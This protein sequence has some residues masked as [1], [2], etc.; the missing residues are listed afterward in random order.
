MISKNIINKFKFVLLILSIQPV[1]AF[2]VNWLMLQGVESP[3]IDHQLFVF[4]QPSYT[5]D[6]GNEISV[7]PNSGKRTASTTIAPWFEDDSKFHIRRARAGIRGNFTGL[8][9]NDFS[10]KMNYF[11]LAEFAPNLLTYRFMG[12]K[13]RTLA[14][15]HFSLTFNHIKGARIRLGLFKTPGLEET[16]QGIPAQD[17]IEFTDFAAREVLERFATGNTRMS[18]SGGTNE[19]IGTPVKI[20]QGFNG[21]RDW[22]VQ[23]FDSFKQDDWDYSYAFMLGRGTGIHE[24]ERVQNMLEQYYYLSAEQSLPGGKGP[25]K[26]GIKYYAWLQNG[27]RIFSSDPQMQAF[28]RKRYGLGVRSQGALFNMKAKQ[29][30]DIGLMFADGMIFVSPVGAVKGG[31][32]MFAAQKGNR[33]RALSIDYGYFIMPKWELMFR[34]DKHELL[35]EADDQVW[36]QGDSKNIETMT[37]GIQHRFTPKIKLTFNFIDRKVTAPYEDHPVIDNVLNSIGQRYSFQLTWIY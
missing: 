19:N 4:I 26:Y 37:Y 8:L 28:E 11:L 20:S 32:L 34:W 24:S 14:L 23:I 31:D 29:R 30:L 6:L 2:S 5:K 15:D 33:S 27:E 21:V 35:Y 1:P 17:Y 9:K 12:P 7:G 36:T 16:Y 25:W 18:P 22:G 3:K 13:K 10:E